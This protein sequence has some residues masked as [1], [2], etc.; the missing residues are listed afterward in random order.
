MG[1]LWDVMGLLEYSYGI[2]RDSKG[3]YGMLWDFMGQFWDVIEPYGVV[4]ACY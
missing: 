1:Q 3:S 2:L 4:K